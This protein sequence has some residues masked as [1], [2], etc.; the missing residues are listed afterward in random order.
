MDCTVSTETCLS[1]SSSETEPSSIHCHLYVQ[2]LTTEGPPG[3]LGNSNS[4]LVGLLFLNDDLSSESGGSSKSGIR[5]SVQID[6]QLPL[7]SNPYATSPLISFTAHLHDSLQGATNCSHSHPLLF[8][9]TCLRRPVTRALTWVFL[10]AG[11][12]SSTPPGH[13]QGHISEEFIHRAEQ[14][15]TPENLMC[16]VSFSSSNFFFPSENIFSCSDFFFFISPCFVCLPASC[17]HISL[18][19]VGVYLWFKPGCLCL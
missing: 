5:C 2:H 4:P 17:Q 19:R 11:E 15:A 3:P 10:S 13:S 16:L 12:S 9:L 14:V 1:G 8:S 6:F 7:V 18:P